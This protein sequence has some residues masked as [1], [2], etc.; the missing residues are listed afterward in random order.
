MAD[1]INLRQ[2]RKRKA[3]E[4]DQKR[5]A[6]NRVNHGL[7]KASRALDKAA[8]DLASKRLDSLKRDSDRTD[9]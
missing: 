8:R 7:T 4:Q 2:A 6:E 3:R 1:V 9:R 5:A